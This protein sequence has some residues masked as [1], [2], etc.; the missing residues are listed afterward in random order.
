MRVIVLLKQERHAA[1]IA[2]LPSAW[3]QVTST[4][5]SCSWRT[6]AA[7]L[8]TGKRCAGTPSPPRISA[9]RARVRGSPP[10]Q[11]C[12]R[13]RCASRL[14]SRVA[15]HHCATDRETLLLAVLAVMPRA[16]MAAR[17]AREWR[18]GEGLRP[19]SQTGR[20]RCGSRPVRST[21]VSAKATRRCTEHNQ[22][23]MPQRDNG[24]RRADRANQGAD[25][26]HST[27]GNHRLVPP[28]LMR[29]RNHIGGSVEATDTA[30]LPCHPRPY[31]K[32]QALPAYRADGASISMKLSATARTFA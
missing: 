9:P 16:S 12:D 3:M 22:V 13:L 15:A 10:L 20:L 8:W 4:S 6:R 5:R 28:G 2:Q 29:P 14:G 21:G 11:L 31:A 27:A 30:T 23:N 18:I 32:T 19:S 25:R 1:R 24:V 17:T 26:Q 7:Q